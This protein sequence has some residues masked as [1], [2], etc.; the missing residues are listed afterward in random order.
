M[1]LLL[2]RR[3]FLAAAATGSALTAKAARASSAAAPDPIRAVVAAD[4][5]GQFTTIQRAIDHVLDTTVQAGRRVI[6]D[7]RPGT[8]RERLKIPQDLP[9]LSLAGAG[10][11]STTVTSS[12][13]AKEAGG[14]FFSSIVEVNGAAF[15]ASGITFENSFGI[16]S[17]AVAIS[18]HSDR[19]IFRNCRFTGWQDTLYAAAGRHYYRHCVI[20]GHVDFIF[21]NAAAVF[22]N[23]QV[24]SRGTGY[25]AAVNRTQPDQPTGFIFRNCRLTGEPGLLAKPR[26]PSGAPATATEVPFPAGN[27]GS[28][29]F[30]GRPWR[31]YARTVFLNCWMGEHI[32]PE[33]W[34]NWRNPANQSTAFF[35]ELGS[36]GPGAHPESR[37]AWARRIDAAGAAAFAPGVFLRGPD[38]W[39]PAP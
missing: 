21:G 28:G 19:A 1:P 16:G 25:I 11:A 5:T 14:T 9:R 38:G 3:A 34:D 27:S 18:V 24:H 20:E 8:Y 30:L 33:G 4:G 29:V 32:R 31:P 36:T 6:L 12:M 35:A 7:I 17:Q 13:S 10:A 15:E 37:V 26:Q 23:C 39:N 2:P 22:D